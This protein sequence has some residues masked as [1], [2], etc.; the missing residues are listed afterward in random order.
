[1]PIL[2]T[3]NDLI[4]QGGLAEPAVANGDVAWTRLAGANFFRQRASPIWSWSNGVA[5]IIVAASAPMPSLTRAS[6]AATNP[7]SSCVGLELDLGVQRLEAARRAG[8][9]VLDR[10]E[11]GQAEAGR[12]PTRARARSSAPRPRRRCP[13]A[14]SARP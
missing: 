14:A 10:A 3:W 9:R 2:Y 11:V 13:A 7:A 4:L 5:W 8:V 1:M 12:A 6:I